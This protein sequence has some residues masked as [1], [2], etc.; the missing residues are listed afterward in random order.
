MKDKYYWIAGLVLG[1]GVIVTDKF[2]HILPDW[3]SIVLFIAAWALIIAGI[4][5]ERA[6]NYDKG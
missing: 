5:M 2:L 3:L 6:K 4:F 1:A